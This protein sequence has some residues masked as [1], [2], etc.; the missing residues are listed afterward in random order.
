MNK[1]KVLFAALASMA[2]VGCADQEFEGVENGVQSG[3]NGKQVEAGLL[4]LGREADTDSRALNP[5]GN[6]VWMPT[7]LESDGKIKDN[8]NQRVGFCWTGR[9]NENPTYGAVTALGGNVYTNYEYEHVGWLDKKATSPALLDCEDNELAN[10]AYLVGQGDPEAKFT[11]SQLTGGRWNAYYAT[12]TTGT[13]EKNA[14]WPA[15]EEF[16]GELNL[17][18]GVFKTNNASVFEGEY[19]VYYPYTD[20]FTKGEIIATLP[21]AYEINT[22]SDA[23]AAASDASFA[24]GYVN[25]YDGGN[26]SSGL[27]AKTL[28]G[29]AIV[30]LYNHHATTAPADK[31]IKKVIVYSKTG[32]LLY[33]QS[34]SAQKS[35]E[36]LAANGKLGTNVYGTSKSEKTNTIVANL[37]NG[38]DEYTTVR[39]TTATAPAETSDAKYSYYTYVAIPMLPQTLQSNFEI[40]LVDDNEKTCRIDEAPVTFTS[41]GA[42]FFDYNLNGK[43]F[44]NEYM[45]VD[46]ASLWDAWT[47]IYSDNS[48]TATAENA[49]NT[50]LVMN[51]ITLANLGSVNGS[52]S[53]NYNSW[54]YNKNV[55]ITTECTNV[56]TITLAPEQLMSIKSQCAA[57]K[58]YTLTFKVPFVVAGA[59]CCEAQ[60]AALVIGGAQDK[61]YD[62]NF[63]AKVTNH[64][65]LVVNNDSKQKS[66]DMY[67][68]VSFAELEN[69]YDEWAEDRNKIVGAAELYL[70]GIDTEANIATLNNKGTVNT[71]ATSI[72][73]E[74]LFTDKSLPVEK[75]TSGIP[76]L[77]ARTN[78]ANITTLN[79][80]GEVEINAYTLVNVNTAL[81]NKIAGSLIKVIGDGHSTIDG[82]MDVKGTSKNEGVIDN[83]GVVNF[84]ASSLDN[85]GL[86]IDRQSGQVGG[87]KVD[88]GTAT[89]TTTKTY[90]DMI[91]ST[92][93][94]KAGI[95]VAQVKT[96]ARF[97]KVLSDAVVEPSTV[98]VEILGMDKYSYN[99]EAF[100]KTLDTKDVYVNSPSKNILFV[101]N[102]EV[103]GENVYT[104]SVFGHCVTVLDGSTLNVKAGTLST[105]AAVNIQQGANFNMVK[106][107]ADNENVTYVTVGTNL[108]NNGTTNNQAALF[109]VNSNLNN[110][111]NA[112]GASSKFVNVTSFLV[113]GNVV[114]SGT[115]DSNGTPNTVKG[116]FT[117]NAGAVTFAPKSTT[118][119]EGTFSSIDGTFEREGLN[120]GNDYRATVNVN[121]LGTL[122]GTTTTA[123]PTEY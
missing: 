9:N 11:H 64:G 114:T 57:D 60:P 75:H 100:E 120:G 48:T 110:N 26:A 102:K 86:F 6:F 61:N 71:D 56:P 84:N 112:T 58:D 91:Y 53:G 20:E 98:V 118:T 49:K 119:I 42:V 52:G 12:A 62:I 101:S 66:A 19:L 103:E 32:E 8:S 54:F 30:R 76:T 92:D 25:H 39:G 65:T 2:L 21:T 5:K 46:E 37:T 106:A 41:N 55:E 85:N 59:D 24:L 69:S 67:K 27:A 13:Y 51:D 78:V 31:N 87:K 40:V 80:E 43:T 63:E 104:E 16:T 77:D 23:F 109:T 82:R 17:G 22:T 50:I 93:L 117:Q 44:K 70:L 35:A 121:T 116:N 108:N 45:A 10:G 107:T 105:I 89:G 94:G 34:L 90:G 83:T 15:H 4:S 7:S 122:T 111:A 99:L 38:T 33:S 123:W 113:K 29:Y 81:D 36:V 96:A 14:N 18:R 79:N 88:N 97:A 72:N 68:K 95:Y 115:F 3:L 47:K 28:N 74:K 73:T 1:N